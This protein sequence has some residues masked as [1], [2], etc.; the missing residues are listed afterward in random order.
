MKNV[1]PDIFAILLIFFEINPD[2]AIAYGLHKLT[3]IKPIKYIGLCL[4]ENVFR[5]LFA[6][7]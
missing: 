3:Q 2:Y 1:F 6:I 5:D 7:L 4:D